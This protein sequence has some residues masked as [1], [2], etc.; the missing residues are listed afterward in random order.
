[1]TG[2]GVAAA[3]AIAAAVEDPE[4]P[5]LTIADLGILRDVRRDSAGLLVV[6]I[7]PTYSGC[8]ANAV[9]ALE[10]EAALRAAGHL[11]A[12]VV[13]EWAPAWSTADIT[14]AGAARLAA[15][16][17]APPSPDGAPPAC[18]RCG[19]RRTTELS[20]FGATACKAL[21]RC[22][23]CREPFEAFKTL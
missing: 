3:R 22:D 12:R 19:D 2:D 21:W 9:I 4:L 17:I 13:T 20:R 14:P 16:G 5:P 10:V 23:A 7:T 11:D 15:L 18:P 6:S 8:P 1:M